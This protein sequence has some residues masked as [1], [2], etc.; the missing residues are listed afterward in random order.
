MLVSDIPIDIQDQVGPSTVIVKQA[1]RHVRRGT[2]SDIQGSRFL[3]RRNLRPLLIEPPFLA[4]CKQ[5]RREALAIY[6]GE[7]SFQ[8]P[9]HNT[10]IRFLAQVPATYA[11]LICSLRALPE[12][13]VWRAQDYVND[14]TSDLA[15]TVRGSWVA[16]YF[17]Q[18]CRLFRLSYDEYVA[19]GRT[20]GVRNDAVLLPA[21]TTDEAGNRKTEWVSIDGLDNYRE[22]IDGGQV[23]IRR[24]DQA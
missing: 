13:Q 3:G 19:I 18:F 23:F 9:N 22:V 5:V 10:T 2:P 14:P 12:W 11:P 7:N 1:Y 8:S 4:T 17:G 16:S 21:P 6:Y 24:K 20:K 15:P